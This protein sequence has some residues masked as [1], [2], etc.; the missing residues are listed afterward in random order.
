MIFFFSGTGNSEW[1]AQKLAEQTRDKKLRITKS[2]MK[3]NW[4]EHIK[5]EKQVGIVFPIYAWAIP[6]IVRQ[7]MNQLVIPKQA[8]RF[9]VSTCGDEVGHALKNVKD[10]DSYYSIIM[11]NNYI[12]GY[13]IDKKE[14][15]DQKVNQAKLRI[16]E[17]SDE[18]IAGKK[19]K[20]L[21]I[22]LFPSIKTWFGYHG[23]ERFMMSARPF[24]VENNCN[25]CGL[26]E[27][28]CPVNNIRLVNGKP[29]WGNECQ[30][31]LGCIHRCPMKAIQYGSNTKKKG[32]YYFSEL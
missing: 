20:N 9:I 29:E 31:C 24:F 23:F 15:T 10:F 25:S 3:L 26:C 32:R 1:V 13:D 11:P 7:F 6:K 4:S 28:I 18:I 19:R 8:F 27:K 16:R 5:E 12:I 30:L 14:I 17:I 21:T 2:M 22:G